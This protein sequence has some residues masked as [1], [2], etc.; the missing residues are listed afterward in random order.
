[1]TCRDSVTLVK[2]A[3]YAI[4]P[5]LLEGESV[6]YT[7]TFVGFTT[8]DPVNCPLGVAGTSPADGFLADYTFHPESVPADTSLGGVWLADTNKLK[9]VR[10]SGTTLNQVYK[11][12]VKA[13]D[14]NGNLV[15][16]TISL[17]ILGCDQGNWKCEKCQSTI[18]YAAAFTLG[19]TVNDRTQ[20]CSSCLSDYPMMEYKADATTGKYYR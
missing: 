13:T 15:T 2:V 18:S 11:I 4:S 10:M 19:T 3:S 8:S 14:K 6:T 20:G 5:T 12:D 17:T 7:D 16:N 9:V 1:M